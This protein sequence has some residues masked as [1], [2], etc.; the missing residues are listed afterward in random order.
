[1]RCGFTDNIVLSKLNVNMS[2]DIESLFTRDELLSLYKVLELDPRP[3]YQND[4]EKIYGMPYAGYDIHFRVDG[5]VLTVID[6][7]RLRRHLC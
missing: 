5:G 6:A 3:R 4:S 1:M 7:V 2:E